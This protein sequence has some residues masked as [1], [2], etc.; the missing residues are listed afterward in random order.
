[1]TW[2]ILNDRALGSIRDIQQLAYNERYL[3]TDFA[4]QPDFAKIAEACSCYG[5]KI[6]DPADVATAFGRALAANEQGIPAVLDFIVAQER[7]LSTTD[8]YP[9]YKHWKK[10]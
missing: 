5:E 8:F 4:V 1:M 7:I 6:E 9:I 3:A 2:C 10:S